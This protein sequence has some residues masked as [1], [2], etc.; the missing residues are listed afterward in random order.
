MGGKVPKQVKLLPARGD[1]DMRV[2]MCVLA[3]EW[4]HAQSLNCH[5]N[6]ATALEAVIPA[7]ERLQCELRV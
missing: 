4:A 2:L 1:C 6:S 7:C 3:C 5:R